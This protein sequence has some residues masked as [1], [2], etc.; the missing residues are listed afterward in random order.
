MNWCSYHAL[1]APLSPVSNKSYH[2]HPEWEGTCWY[3]CCTWVGVEWLSFG[4][5]ALAI[6]IC[7]CLSVCMCLWSCIIMQFPI[8][9]Q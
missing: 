4:V 8:N 5:Y 2:V 6:A 3:V 9:V 7:V 1:A